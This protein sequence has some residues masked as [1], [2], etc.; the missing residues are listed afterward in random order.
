MPKITALSVSSETRV[1]RN[2]LVD[3]IIS[4]EKTQDEKKHYRPI[5]I[6]PSNNS[7]W[8]TQNT[9]YFRTTGS[10]NQT[11]NTLI[12]PNPSDVF[13]GTWLPTLGPVLEPVGEYP[14]GWI[15]KLDYIVKLFYENKSNKVFK[16]HSYLLRPGPVWMHLMLDQL[17]YYEPLLAQLKYNARA[18]TSIND[19]MSVNSSYDYSLYLKNASVHEIELFIKSSIKTYFIIKL[20]TNYFLT[21][22]QFQ[23]SAQLGGGIWD[24]NDVVSIDVAKHP[25]LFPNGLDIHIMYNELR[26]FVLSHTFLND[27]CEFKQIKKMSKINVNID[28]QRLIKEQDYIDCETDSTLQDKYVCETLESNDAYMSPENYESLTNPLFSSHLT[29]LKQT[30]DVV[31]KHL[32]IF[33]Y[34]EIIN[35]LS[36]S[37]TVRESKMAAPVVAPVAAPVP[38]PAPA[39]IQK[40]P[41]RNKR[42]KSPSPPTKRVLRPRK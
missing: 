27:T 42:K 37:I 39:P 24:F 33:P 10:S 13:R 3:V 1:P 9:A 29:G 12:E 20:I 4:C 40:S 16:Q 17:G 5:L 8:P 6:F 38:V 22:E 23:R 35:T 31:Q 7:R 14:A 2:K 28:I 26:N 18:M 34:N 36:Q 41:T 21:W 25:K 30:L 32:F 19:L 15:S 11:A